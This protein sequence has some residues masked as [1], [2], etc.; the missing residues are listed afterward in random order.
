MWDFVEMLSSGKDIVAH[1]EHWISLKYFQDGVH[2]A[3]K[4]DA[5][6]PCLVNCI[7]L[8]KNDG[9]KCS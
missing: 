7:K 1:G 9:L 8:E 3:I 2:L 6:F 5:T 4:A